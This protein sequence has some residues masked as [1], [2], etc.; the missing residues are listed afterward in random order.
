MRASKREAYLWRSQQLV[1]DESHEIVQL[2][3]GVLLLAAR[4]GRVGGGGCA[5]VGV[6]LLPHVAVKSAVTPREGVALR[7]GCRLPLA[8][9]STA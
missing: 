4:R 5:H 3:D 1:H 9:G 2:L 6:P 8:S 7:E